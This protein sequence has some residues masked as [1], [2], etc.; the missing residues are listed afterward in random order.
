[1]EPVTTYYLE[2]TKVTQL[3]T[4]PRPENL[5]ISEVEIKNYRF[6]RFL[7]QLIGEPWHWTDKLSQSPEQWQEYAHADNLRTWVAYSKGSIAGYF[8]LQKQEDNAVEIVYFGLA[9]DF[10]NQ[11]F[12]GYLL[13]HAI[14]AAWAWGNVSRVWVHT[15][16]LDHPYALANYQGRGMR[17][18]HQEQ[19]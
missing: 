12:G 5:L 13:S 2:M 10:L 7:Y 15:C 1:M 18:Y 17:I 19:E 8:E 3:K 9:P 6:N 16:S 11:G 4:K 14:E